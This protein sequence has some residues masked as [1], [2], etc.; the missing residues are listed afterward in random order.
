MHAAPK[1]GGTLIAV[2]G[3]S[4]RHLNPAV[5][6]GVV[7]GVPG[8]QIFASPLRYDANWQPQPYLAKRWEVSPDG[9]AVTLHLVEEAT[10]HDGHPVTSEDVAF[11]VQV[12]KENHPFQTM[13]APVER[14]E[15]PD[16][17]TAILRLAQPHPAILLAMSPALLPILPKHVFG[18]GQDLKTHPRNLAPIGAGPFKFVEYKPGEYIILERNEHFFLKGKPYLDRI[19]FKIILDKSTEALAFERGEAHYG[20]YSAISLRVLDRL[21]KLPHLKTTTRGYEA[22]GPLNWL[23]FNLRR[24]PLDD[25]RVRKAISYAIDR[26]FITQRLHYGRSRRATGPIAPDSPFYT[27][28]VEPYDLDLARANRLLDAAGHVRGADGTRFS[29]TI[30]YIP[31]FPEQQK[32][33]AEYLKSQLKKIGI[34]LQVRAAPDFPTWAQR[35]ANWEFDLTLDIVFN[36]GDP[37]IGVHRTYLCSN[38]R[39]GVI[40]SNT[41]GYCNPKVDALLAQAAVELDVEKRRA[42]YHAFQRL[43]VDE[44]PVA[45]INVVPFHT[46]YHADL[47]GLPLSIWGAFSP[48]DELYWERPPQ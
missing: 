25:L 3:N 19:I 40:W 47:R 31:G 36:W 43:V 16:A 12:V 45:W 42:L 14:V 44:L 27:D 4:P 33:I 28:E 7:T 32:N 41:Q 10:F 9:L 26:D 5:Q 23:A 15:T 38:V 39:K 13:F 46:L 37:V 21:E 11:S 1:R 48:F 8:T 17:H 2:L 30:D 6:S 35:V 34:D 20:A 29:L 18:D 24:K 22:I